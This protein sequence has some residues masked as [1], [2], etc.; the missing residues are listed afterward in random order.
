M[1]LTTSSFL[2]TFLIVAM[3]YLHCWTRT[4]MPIRV[5]I[6]FPKIGAVTTGDLDPD[7]ILSPNLCEGNNFYTVQCSHQ[8]WSPN[9]SQ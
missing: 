1:N 5:P 8:V 6:S 9:L 2:C 3:T 4:R 7:Q